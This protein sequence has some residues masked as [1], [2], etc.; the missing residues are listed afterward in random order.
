MSF[1]DKFLKITIVAALVLCIILIK[2]SCSNS[3]PEAVTYVLEGDT[4]YSHNNYPEHAVATVTDDT[5]P[6]YRIKT[7]MQGK[8]RTVF[9]DSNA[10]QLVAA[11]QN[12]FRPIETLRDAYN[13]DKPI[14]KVTT[15]DEYLI[16]TL[17]HSM[18][19]LVPKAEKLLREIGRAFS[20]TIRA[21]GGKDYRIKVTSL[22]R[23]NYSVKALKRRN[24]AATDESCHLYGTTFD[25]SW[26]HFDCLDT[27]FVVSLEDLKNIL[28]EVILA[29]RDKGRC[30][31]IYEHKRGCFHITVR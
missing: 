10:I 9:N 20:D 1:N 5:V 17:T 7:Y 30:Y 11:Q 22:T 25:I 6:V 12:G 14:V 31:A 2:C 13:I 21:R 26:A 8:L 27:S 15:C 19:Y 23:S 18:P 29:F 16:D 4:T 28:G 24:R 3:T